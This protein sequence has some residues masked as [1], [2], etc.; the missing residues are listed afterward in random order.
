MFG[1]E[2]LSYI[3]HW[4]H[5]NSLFDYIF[6]HNHNCHHFLSKLNFYKRTIIILVHWIHQKNYIIFNFYLTTSLDSPFLFIFDN[7]QV[8]LTLSFYFPSSSLV[9]VFII[10]TN[11][12]KVKKKLITFVYFYKLLKKSMQLLV[13]ML[14]YWW[15]K[16]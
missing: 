12:Q 1:T 2:F 4:N 6:S 8:V 11:A 15:K 16:E 9:S 13:N 7:L 5:L 10:I 3:V 14:K